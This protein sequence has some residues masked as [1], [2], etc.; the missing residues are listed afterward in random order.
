M[1]FVLT[2]AVML[3][4]AILAAG[5][6]CWVRAAMRIAAGQPLVP[7]RPRQAVPWGLVD[8]IGV[9]V[10]YFVAL[11]AARLTL[12]AL[13]WLPDVQNE[14]SLTLADKGLLVGA[15]IGM[16]FGLLVVALP[17]IALHT[18][19]T[20]RD[21]G[22]AMPELWADVKLG[23]I[24]FVMLAPPVYAIQGALVYFW[25]PSKHPL[26]EMFKSS[27]DAGFFAVLLVA[28]AVAAPIFE[29]LVFRV[30]LQGFLEKLASFRGHA[31]EALEL[32]IGRLPRSAAPATT[33]LVAAE[34]IFPEADA[35]DNPFL[36]PAAASDVPVRAELVDDGWQHELRGGAAWLPIVLVSVLFALLHYSHGPDWVALTLLAAGM[37][38]L[39]QRTHSVVPS[40]VVHALLNSLSMLGLWVQVYAQPAS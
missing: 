11:V 22:L 13:G 1:Q 26:M 19:G 31:F 16:Q 33:T 34:P 30:L 8:L 15:N 3:V 6:V 2:V 20:R 18:G 29:E 36:P 10:L 17:L 38:Y 4:T 32:L 12:S 39:Y 5:I 27:P 35:G 40:L 14:A 7:W 28:A 24:G 37:G 23:L 25:K 9:F 21:F